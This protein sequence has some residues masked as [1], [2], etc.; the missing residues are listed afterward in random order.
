LYGSGWLLIGDASGFVD[1]IFSSGVDIAM[2]S[3]VFAYESILPLLLLGCWSD[4]DEQFALSKY[5]ERVRRGV[6]VWTR[7]VE[8]F[9][10]FIRRLRRLAHEQWALPAICR[11]LQGNPYEMQNQLIVDQLFDWVIQGTSQSAA[12]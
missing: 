6:E 7:S 10:G 1:P 9:Y 2:Y 8:L 3:A 12:V 4:A 5:E 11:F